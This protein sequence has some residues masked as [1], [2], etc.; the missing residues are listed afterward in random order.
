MTENS[1]IDPDDNGNGLNEAALL[2]IK[3]LLYTKI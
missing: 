3:P 2:T 1:S